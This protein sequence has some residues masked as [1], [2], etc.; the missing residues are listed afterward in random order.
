MKFKKLAEDWGLLKNIPENIY[1]FR[2][3]KTYISDNA[4]GRY[5]EAEEKEQMN[6][7]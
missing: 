5:D 7:E 3:L 6:M 2:T 4:F 1:L